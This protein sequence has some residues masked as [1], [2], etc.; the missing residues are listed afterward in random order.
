MS[1]LRF[2]TS[3]V[4]RYLSRAELCRRWGISRATSYRYEREGYI[5]KPVRF[6]PGATRFPL[7]EIERVEAQAAKDRGQAGEVA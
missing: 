3:E 4:A 7:A 1:V 2:A 5:P 6:G